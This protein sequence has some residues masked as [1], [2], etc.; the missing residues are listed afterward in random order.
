MMISRIAFASS[1]TL[2]IAMNGIT[3]VAAQDLHGYHTEPP[4]QGPP[5]PSHGDAAMG[6]NDLGTSTAYFPAAPFTSAP[7]LVLQQ[8][9]TQKAEGN[10]VITDEAGQSVAVDPHGQATAHSQ[11]MSVAHFLHAE[12]MPRPVSIPGATRMPVWKTPYS[13]GHFGA[14]RNRQ[15]SL[16]HGHQH[17]YTQWTLR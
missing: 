11:G 12:K 8:P 2:L 1:L 3:A 5:P 16:H 9:P 7:H 17:A 4:Y 13:Y 6:V 14:S 10:V 15:W